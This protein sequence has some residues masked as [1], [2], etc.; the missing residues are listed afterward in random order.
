M[1]RKK[2]GGSRGSAPSFSSDHP[3]LSVFCI[4]REARD[5]NER[6][7]HV[8]WR[9]ATLVPIERND[10]ATWAVSPTGYTEPVREGLVMTTPIAGRVVQWLIG[11]V[12]VP[13]DKSPFASSLADHRERWNLLCGQ[14]GLASVIA[15]PSAF[16]PSLDQL[17][18]AGVREVELLHFVHS[19]LS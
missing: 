13:A 6:E 4:G 12:W 14:C 11:N 15:N 8:K 18:S 9:I 5:E 10:V 17:S 7:E 19:K 16:Y 3:Y 1:T 2:N